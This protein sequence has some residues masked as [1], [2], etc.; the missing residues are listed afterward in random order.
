MM[1]VDERPS[2][3]G[4][5]KRVEEA[6]VKEFINKDFSVESFIDKVDVEISKYDYSW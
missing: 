5:K 2:D 6:L 4:I 1:S 3:E